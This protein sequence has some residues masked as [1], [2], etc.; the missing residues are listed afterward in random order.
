MTGRYP[1]RSPTGL[2]GVLSEKA[3]EL[4]VG[5]TTATPTLAMLLKEAGYHTGLFG[6]WHLGWPPEFQPKA[7][8]FDV[9]FGPLGGALDYISHVRPS[10]EHDLYRNG[11][12]V[13][14]DG[15]ITDL[16]TEEAMTFL[17]E[18][19]PPFF[20]SMQYTA[21]HWPWQRRGD[22][23]YPEDWSW[24]RDGGSPETY[25]EM[26]LALDQGVGRILETLEEIGHSEDTL[27]IFTSD[28][29]GDRWSDMGPIR[30]RKGYLWEGG[31]RVPAFV[32]WPGVI[33]ED[34]S[35]DQVVTTLD[36]SA[37]MLTAAGLTL[38]IELDGM[39]MLPHLKGQA[40]SQERTV[41]WRT[42][43]GRQQKAVRSGRWKYLMIEP[44]D[45]IEKPVTGEYLFDLAE[46][47]GEAQDLKQ[48]ER[49]VFQRLKALYAEWEADVLEPIALPARQ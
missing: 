21:T 10:G 8:G 40:P 5:L 14:R 24:S 47:P 34:L 20:L 44:L 27:V 33:P 7:H 3:K 25:A 15:Y 39:D 37:T 28:N 49:E 16:L 30:S 18:T 26:V 22:E 29:G 35:T 4:G 42:S 11:Q 41:F 43:W 23:P 46:D 12:E 6:K 36:W 1:A 2:W 9:S 13:H 48:G 32:R 31:I 38:P 19:Q 45:E 17:R